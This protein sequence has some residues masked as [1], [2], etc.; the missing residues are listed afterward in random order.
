MSRDYVI[1]NGTN[2]LTISGLAIK[3][4]PP[5]SKPLMRTMREEIDGRD[6][7]INTELGYQA[8]DKPLEVGLFG[9]YDINEIIAFFNSKGTIVFSDEPD[10]FYNFEILDKIDFTKLVK[11]RTAMVNIHCQPFKYPTTE[12]P[13]EVAYEYVEGTGENITLDNT[14]ASSLSLELKGNTSQVSYT[15]KNKIFWISGSGALSNLV[16]TENS[17]KSINITGTPNRSWANLTPNYLYTLPASTW[18]FSINQTLGIR[19]GI[20]LFTQDEAYIEHGRI[21]PGSTSVTFTTTQET[22]RFR[23]YL[24]QLST[25]TT[26]SI[27]NLQIQLE[28]GTTATSYEP[29]VGGIP[30]PNPNYPQD[31]E[32]VTGDNEITICGKNLFKEWISATIN[33][34]TGVISSVARNLTNPIEVQPST[35]YTMWR[36]DTGFAM[37]SIEFDKNDNWLAKN[38]ITSANT[39]QTFTTNANTKYVRLYQYTGYSPT[40]KA[41]LEVGSTATTYEAYQSQTYP[42]TLGNLEMCNIGTYEDYFEY[43]NEKWYK[44]GNIGKIILSNSASE[45]WSRSGATTEN[46]FVGALNLISTALDT[47]F[48]TGNLWKS[49]KFIYGSFGVNY[50]FIAYNGSAEQGYQFLALS[51]P[52]TLASDID[53]FKTWLGSNNV[54]FYYILKTETQTEITDT[55][56]KG[57]LDNI[58][59]ALSY[60]GQT[61]ITQTND[62]KPFRISASALKKGSDTAV[63][64]NTGNIY[65]KPT[66]ELEGTGVVNIYK[67]GSQAFEV[68]LSEENNITIDTDKMEAYTDTSLANRK[69]TGDYS[70]FKLDSGTSNIKFD[71]ALTSAT[72]TNYKRWL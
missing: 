61:N 58:R 23:L 25:S 67:D 66:I 65:S 1:I 31:I 48:N 56:L 72:I 53:N 30:S 15:G 24:E 19:V 39:T 63:V 42:L 64:N 5:I 52:S 22:T 2:S 27:T 37:Y 40:N 46:T 50:T 71:G 10:K 16:V 3:T 17:D 26:Y 59:E 33:P 29:Y 55:T 69:V 38:T 12:T 47:K 49:D 13:I 32:V 14:E 18:T 34:D 44:K 8:Y 28:T 7:D 35:T 62:N 20:A 21:L 51:I 60:S 41:Q 45:Y 43:D 57:Q 4:L 36:E 9:N 54:T 6:G 68:D 70:K 11:F